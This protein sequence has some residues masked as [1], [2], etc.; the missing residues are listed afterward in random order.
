MSS[1][2]AGIELNGWLR[3]NGILAQHASSGYIMPEGIV[4]IIFI[5][6]WIQVADTGSLSGRS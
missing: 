3:F 1:D 5:A 6:L 4:L 2:M